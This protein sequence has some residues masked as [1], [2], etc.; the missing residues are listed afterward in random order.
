MPTIKWQK[1]ASETVVNFVLILNQI[2][3]DNLLLN[4]G[5]QLNKIIFLHLFD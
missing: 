2:S 3:S 5:Q 1:D 4:S